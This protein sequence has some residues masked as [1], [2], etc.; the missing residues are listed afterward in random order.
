MKSVPDVAHDFDQIADALAGGPPDRTFTGA[1]RAVLAA[2]PPSARSALDVGCGD[3]LLARA[4]ARRG[5]AV[6]AIDVAAQMIALAQA[7]SQPGVSVDYRVADVMHTATLAPNYDV[8]L[9]VSMVHHVPLARIVPTLAA[10]VAPGGVLII[11]DVVTRRGLR[12][13]PVNVIAGLWARARRLIRRDRVS[14]R[15]RQLYAEHGRGEAYLEPRAVHNA[16]VAY[17]PGVRVMHH[18]GWRYTAIWSA[19][20]AT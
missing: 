14:S 2:I 20:A 6:T 7:R 1:E 5:M 18:L 10:L 8:V 11:Q 16:L 9:S 15:V 12:Y 4:L 17:L 19:A 13:L 3:G